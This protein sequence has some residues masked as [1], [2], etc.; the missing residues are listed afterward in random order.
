VRAAALLLLASSACS[1]IFGLDS[2]QVVPA[3]A[4]RMDGI[5]DTAPIDASA[6]GAIAVTISFQQGSN[7]YASTQDTWI[8]GGSPNQ[9]RDGDTTIHWKAAQRWALIQFNAIFGSMAGRI[10]QQATIQSARLSIVMTQVSCTGELREVAIGWVDTVTY[11][12]FGATAGVDAADLGPVVNPTPTVLNQSSIDVTSSL[13]KWRIDPTT[14]N[15]WILEGTG[16][17][18][19]CIARSSDDGVVANRPMLTVT[20][21]P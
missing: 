15:G 11:N 14:N 3:D 10:P 17:G 5:V 18:A 19:D 4:P 12:T 9:T 20:Y 1:Q 16:G 2:P 8:D 7:A 21:L 13:V 6:D